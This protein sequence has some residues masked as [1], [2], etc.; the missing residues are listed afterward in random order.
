MKQN[1]L[2]LLPPQLKNIVAD[3]YDLILK[4]ALV[5]AYKNL[6]EEEKAKI[7]QTFAE[8]SDEEKEKFLKKY[9]QNFPHLFLEEAKKFTEEI[10][11]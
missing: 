11:R 7:A 4:R 3:S 2:N 1:F 6:T 5:R 10:K 8:G 9:L